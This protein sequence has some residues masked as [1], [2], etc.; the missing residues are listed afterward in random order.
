MKEIPKIEINREWCKNCGICV[1]FCPKN[2]Y[3]FINNEPIVSRPENCTECDLC[4]VLCP[5]FAI[6]IHGVK[7][8][9]EKV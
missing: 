1:E 9:K 2:V 7:S 6:I 8:K 4:V 3:D 5:D